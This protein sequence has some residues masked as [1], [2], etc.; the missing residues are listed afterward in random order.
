MLNTPVLLIT[1]NRPTHTKRVL[2]SILSAQPKELYVFQDGMRQGNENDTTKCLQVREIIANMTQGKPVNV[3]TYYSDKNWGC[4]AGPM[5][6]ITWFF[7]QVERG[8]VMEDDCLPHPDF[9]AY[10]EELLERY[11]SNEQVLFINATLYRDRWQ[12]EH[13]YDFSR[14]MVTGAWAGWKRTWQGF[15]LDLKTLD[16]KK[17]RKHVWKLTG[18]IVDATWW[19]SIVREIQQDENKKSYWDYQMQIHL[20]LN[21][22]LTIHPRRNLV[23]NIGFDGEGTHT[24]DNQSNRG[25]RPVYPILPLTHPETITVDKKRDSYCWSKNKSSGW[26]K[27]R[28]AY[29]YADILWSDGIGHKILMLYKKIRGKDI[30]TLKV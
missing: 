6:G 30:N 26:L 20:F 18:N 24:L 25:D 21:N 28:I 9:Y 13:S 12:C 15:D 7:N 29:I 3:H 1:F 22:A 27:D 4:G 2:E 23:S 5:T 14:Y 10:C 17:F 16:A 11:D 19:Y 8:I